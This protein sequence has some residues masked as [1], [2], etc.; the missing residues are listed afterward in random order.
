MGISLRAGLGVGDIPKVRVP[1]DA[2]SKNTGDEIGSLKRRG[3]VGGSICVTEKLSS[4]LNGTH[5]KHKIV[6]TVQSF[7]HHP[8]KHWWSPMEAQ[9]ECLQINIEL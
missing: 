5:G 3:V 8:A 4:K 7:A 9:T 1:L 6:S 2:G